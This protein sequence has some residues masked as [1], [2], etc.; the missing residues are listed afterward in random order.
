MSPA[1][2]G[3]SGAVVAAVVLSFAAGCG[4]TDRKPE[5]RTAVESYVTAVNAVQA[6]SAAAFRKAD[7][8]LRA[9][10]TAG[11]GRAEVTRLTAAAA[12][13]RLAESRLRRIG[14]PPEAAA[15]HRHLLELYAREVS[16]TIEVRDMSRFLAAARRTLAGARTLDAGSR[17]LAPADVS[18]Y[19]A[20]LRAAIGELRRTTPP[21]VLRPWRTDELRWLAALAR[22][23]DSLAAALRAGDAGAARV[24]AVRFRRVASS[25]P[26]VTAAQRRALVAYNDRSR[27]ISRL[28]RRLALEQAALD[29]KLH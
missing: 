26:G 21:A 7:T 5:R 15:I 29:A 27:E 20:R 2:F 14:P 1:P 17:A 19:G 23:V 4:G 11:G 16:L 12:Q 22:E 8:A 6:S 9:F 28:R 18:R 24:F 10:G 13:F 3:T 25:A